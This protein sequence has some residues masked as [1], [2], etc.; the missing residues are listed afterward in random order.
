[1]RLA[2]LL[3]AIGLV[4]HS[5]V[6]A[7]S[8]LNDPLLDRLIGTWVLRGDIAGKPVTHGVKVRW[9][10]A[11]QYIQI[12][13]TSRS[14]TATGA[15]EYDAIVYIGWNP[16]LRQYTCLWLDSTG[17]NGLV[18]TAFGHAE[19]DT[20]KLAF[21]WSDENGDASLHNTFAYD[22]ITNTWRWTIDNVDKGQLQPFAKV[23]L[24]RQ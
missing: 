4:A 14:R 18:G 23:K 21:V 24:T 3:A 22:P 6:A 15:P 19:A 11:H 10:L 20:A 17:G 2:A 1:M 8:S 5:T 16:D 9:V 7:P 12:R 13:E